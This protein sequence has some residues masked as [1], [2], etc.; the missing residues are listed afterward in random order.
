[1]P[2]S[3]LFFAINSSEYT[4]RTL[5]INRQFLPH[6]IYFI[7]VFLSDIVVYLVKGAYTVCKLSHWRMI[8][9]C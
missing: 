4:K 1:M 6:F 9:A 8:P 5:A 2:A 7:I 3:F